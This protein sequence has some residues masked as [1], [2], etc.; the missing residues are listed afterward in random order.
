[1]GDAQ[2]GRENSPQMVLT[3]VSADRVGVLEGWSIGWRIE[4]LGEH[5]I[6]VS[7]VRLP[8]GQF[9]SAERRFDPA[10][11]LAPGNKTELNILVKCDEPAGLV[12]ENAFVILSVE[13]L[14]EQW[15]IFV[16]LRVM[17]TVDGRPETATELITTQ[18]VGF[19][20]V[21]S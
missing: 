14:G 7:A 17:V 15:R 18:R 11:E 6:Y 16:R 9:K 19:S 2:S 20:G 4:N 5:P 12:T 21:A 8:H 10:I 13:W 3:Q 1:M